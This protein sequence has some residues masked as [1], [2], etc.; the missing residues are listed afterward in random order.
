M[1]LFLM[2]T[3]SQS[4][5][6]YSNERLFILRSFFTFW[7]NKSMEVSNNSGAALIKDSVSNGN[8][9]SKYASRYLLLKYN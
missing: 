3:M 7:I 2:S 6:K 1:S 5:Y 8:K 9:S 4:E